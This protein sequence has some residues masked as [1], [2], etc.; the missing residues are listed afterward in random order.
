MAVLE[1]LSVN[2]PVTDPVDILVLVVV[3]ADVLQVV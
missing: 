3:V 2:S 1:F